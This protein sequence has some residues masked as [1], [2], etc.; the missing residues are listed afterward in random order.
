MNSTVWDFHHTVYDN[1]VLGYTGCQLCSDIT[2]Y[3]EQNHYTMYLQNIK[4][5][6]HFSNSIVNVLENRFNVIHQF[7]NDVIF[8]T[9]TVIVQLSI[10]GA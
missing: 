7:L 3:T 9:K 4:Y 5:K 10:R 1:A 6:M 2:L 8:T